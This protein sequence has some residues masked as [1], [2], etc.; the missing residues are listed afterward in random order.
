MSHRA[1]PSIN[2]WASAGGVAGVAAVVGLF[3]LV[4]QRSAPAR[5]S[6]EAGLDELEF[7]PG[8]IARLGDAASDQGALADA[9][10]A[11]APTVASP[12]IDVAVDDEPAIEPPA[13]EPTTAAVS[14]DVDAP[15]T[16]KP[17]TPAARPTPSPSAGGSGGGKLPGP[18]THAGRPFG[19]PSGWDDLTRDG[20]PW[21]TAVLEV[22]AGMKVQGFARKVGDGDVRFQI[23][24]CKD[25][26]IDAVTRK[27]GSA[28]VDVVDAVV[29]AVGRLRFPPIPAELAAQMPTRCAK[30]RYTFV[31]S[32]AATH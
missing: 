18:P 3:A 2:R 15:A 21:A 13:P 30:I 29:L 23:S 25:G 19:D 16:P 4:L 31:W 27:G 20:D 26:S 24:V 17:R 8:T 11:A 32:S 1:A 10:P 6:D 5:A 22:M 14:T 28:A 7:L 9:P 12:I